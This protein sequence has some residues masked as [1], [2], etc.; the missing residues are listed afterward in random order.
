MAGDSEVFRN[1]SPGLS[2]PTRSNPV[3]IGF[4]RQ[5]ADTIMESN[6]CSCVSIVQNRDFTLQVIPTTSQRAKNR[7]KHFSE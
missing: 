6:I 1:T 3:Y 5:V 4:G 2:V 7:M